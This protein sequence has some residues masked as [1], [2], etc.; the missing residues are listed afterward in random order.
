M[1]GRRVVADPG[2]HRGLQVTLFLVCS[3]VMVLSVVDIE[4]D[5]ADRCG[6][7][8]RVNG[9]RGSRIEI[10]DGNRDPTVAVES[11]WVVCVQLAWRGILGMAVHRVPRRVGISRQLANFGT[12][13]E[14][15]GEPFQPAGRVE[16]IAAHRGGPRDV[17]GIGQVRVHRVRELT[18]RIGVLRMDGNHVL[19]QVVPIEHIAHRGR[20][21]VEITEIR[22]VSFP[23]LLGDHRVAFGLG[24]VAPLI[25]DP[26]RRVMHVG[27]LAVVLIGAVLA[28]L[29]DNL[30]R[31]A[32]FAVGRAVV[33]WSG[34]SLGRARPPSRSGGSPLR[35]GGLSA[36]SRGAPMRS[37]PLTGRCPDA[38]YRV[39]RC[40]V[41]VDVL[42][43][44]AWGSTGVTAMG[45]WSIR[46]SEPGSWWC[47][48]SCWSVIS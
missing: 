24:Q 19:D 28:E 17:L 11:R 6:D 22:A 15:R 12:I 41:R 40:P 8:R 21:A 37:A 33:Q 31:V 13:G 25:A 42:S 44:P 27:G 43:P 26:L 18:D 46:V 4:F 48:P 39:G 5:A 29:I 45:G 36:G 38:P 23:G 30:C 20:Q 1:T 16:L 47:C 14:Q 35:G 9:H 7:T 34:S 2:H 10:A 32:C 3:D